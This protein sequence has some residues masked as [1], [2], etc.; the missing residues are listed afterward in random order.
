MLGEFPLT[1]AIPTHL[2][3]YTLEQNYSLYTDIDQAGWRFIMRVSR[4]FF[5]DHAH[6]KYLSGIQATG[7]HEEYIPRISEM[8]KCLQKLGW[9]AV[10]VSGFLPPA[11]FLEFISLGIL[12]I[13]CDMR[14]L[15][16]L[17]YT[18]APDIVHEAAGHAP[19]IADPDYSRYLRRYGEIARKV[20]YTA[21]DMKVYEAIRDLSEV[22]EDP[23]STLVDIEASME[24]LD[25]ALKSVTN[26]SEAT[27]LSRMEW[28]TTE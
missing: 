3:H 26:E 17:S 19:I 28:W 13:A 14:S 23:K 24:R 8:D 7:M 2:K 10:V 16:H 9:R 11:I 25:F 18:P 12:P 1:K 4:H 21:E 27:L 6:P 5:K 22:K 15:D 20:I